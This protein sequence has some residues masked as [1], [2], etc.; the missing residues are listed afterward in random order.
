M[1]S[2]YILPPYVRLYGMTETSGRVPDM[3][4]AGWGL[5]DH[6]VTLSED[7]HG[8]L[9]QV[10]GADPQQVPAPSQDSIDLPASRLGDPGYD[11]LISVV[12]KENVRTDARHRLARLGGKSTIDLLRRREGDTSNAPDAVVLPHDHDEVLAILRACA[13]HGIAVV[14]FGGGTSVVGGV[15]PLRA[16]F[17]A[18]VQLDL[19]RMAA[20]IAV[21]RESSTARLQ[22]GLKAPEAEELL[23]AEGLTLGHFPQSFEHASIGGFAATRS[24]GQASSGYG[25]FDDMVLAMTVAT[26]SGTLDL[27]RAPASAAGPDL[28]QLFL[29][30]EGCLGVIT[31]VTVRVHPAPPAVRDEAWTFPDFHTGTAAL[32]Q[33]AQMGIAPTIARLSDETETGVNLAMGSKIGSQALTGGCLAIMCYEG[34]PAEIQRHREIVTQMLTEAGGSAL[35]TEAASHWREGRF[36]APYLRDALLDAGVLVE[37]L[38]TATSWSALPSLYTAVSQALTSSLED[39]GSPSM[40]LCHVSHIYPTGASLYF[41]VAA[42]AGDRPIARWEA[43]KRA[44]SDA[45]AKQGA[46]ITHH[47]AVGTDHRDWIE[48]EIGELGISVLRSVKAAVDPAGILNPGKL[49]PPETRR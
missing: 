5:D 25:R 41:T 19:H 44:A 7:V 6:H 31:E 17:E 34:E 12:G 29:G 35:G 46:T 28:R 27:G 48:A 47:H 33:L 24:A 30:S 18:V 32:R 4:W 39:D 8:L 21:D 3:R 16:Q 20:L 14:P 36:H 38:E 11:A 43:A 45:I 2:L 13:E 1:V 40:V 23:R 10:L 49:I 42:A 37:T 9:R 26:P 22:P 15:E